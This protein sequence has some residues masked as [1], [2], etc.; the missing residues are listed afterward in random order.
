MFYCLR[1]D[2]FTDSKFRVNPLI[3]QSFIA[4]FSQGHGRACDLSSHTVGC[5]R[6]LTGSRFKVS[7]QSISHTGY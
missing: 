4:K 5:V 1:A 3:N 2:I 6:L 7:C